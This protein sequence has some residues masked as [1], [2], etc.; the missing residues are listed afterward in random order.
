[1]IAADELMRFLSHAVNC[2]RFCFWHRQSVVF[3][4]VYEISRE[5]LNGSTSVK[6]TRDKNDIFGPRD[7]FQVR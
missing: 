1:M 2:G 7:G 3:L 5:P 4:S 6:V